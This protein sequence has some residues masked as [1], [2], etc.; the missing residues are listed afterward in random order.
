MQVTR[1]DE[2]WLSPVRD[3]DSLVIHFSMNKMN[4]PGRVHTLFRLLEL[5]GGF[6]ATHTLPSPHSQRTPLILSQG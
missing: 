2:L 6:A 1:S 4:I 3:R 5:L